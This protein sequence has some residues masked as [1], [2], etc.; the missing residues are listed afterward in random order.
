MSKKP[1]NSIVYSSFLRNFYIKS[2]KE[3]KD[4]IM[5]KYN[6]A[7]TMAF[8]L[9]SNNTGDEVTEKELIRALKRRVRELESAGEAIEACGLPYDTYEN[10]KPIIHF[11]PINEDTDRIN[12]TVNIC[13]DE[14]EIYVSLFQMSKKEGESLGYIKSNTLEYDK[15][16]RDEVAESL[17]KAASEFLTEN[18]FK[19]SGTSSIWRREE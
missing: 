18:G 11:E 5:K 8:S 13:Q 4:K 2:K 12:F 15:D 19:Y 14:P 6:H 17:S 16:D 7:F 10:T 3:I 9:N 1:F